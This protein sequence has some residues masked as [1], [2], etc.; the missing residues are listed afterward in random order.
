MTLRRS[1]IV[2]AVLVAILLS[3]SCA[4]QKQ[5]SYFQDIMEQEQSE[6][7]NFKPVTL[8][9]KPGDRL[10]ILVNTQDPRLTSLFNLAIV[11][12]QV[13]LDT[14]YDQAR[15]LSGYTVDTKGNINF[16]VLG[17]IHV[18][19]MT[20]EAISELIK[21]KLQSGELV[22]D[23]VVTVEYLN[24]NISVMGEVN[25][26]GKYDIKR[27]QFTVLD[28][29]SMAGDLTIY[30]ER[31]NVLVLR[32]DGEKQQIYKLDLTSANGLYSSPAYY[33]RQNDVVYVKP[34]ASKIRQS[35][36]A[37]NTISNPSFWLS[38]ASVMSTIAVLI[39]K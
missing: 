38:V 14:G 18:E 4:M 6:L 34:N 12:Q 2:S 23:P 13:G 11:S 10:S 7:D 21:E 17:E 9:M 29:L 35:T 5:V 39:F 20:R 24:L 27:D 30:G 8:T 16:P 31:K 19:G 32:N 36:V 15:G 22:K 26:P 33:L 28:A 3:S 37:G 1:G 25:K